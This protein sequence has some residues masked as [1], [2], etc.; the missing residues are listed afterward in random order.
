MKVKMIVTDIPKERPCVCN[1]KGFC[2]YHAEKIREQEGDTGVYQLEFRFRND[3]ATFDKENDVPISLRFYFGK[4][5]EGDDNHLSLKIENKS[6]EQ[7]R[8]Y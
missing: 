4:N 5:D 2:V 7:P 8:G 3:E 1:E 6:R